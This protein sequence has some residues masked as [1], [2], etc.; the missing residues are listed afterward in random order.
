V[1]E[2]DIEIAISSSLLSCRNRKRG[3]LGGFA[4][5]AAIASSEGA[6]TVFIEG[7]RKMAERV[8]FFSMSA[9][10]A[11]AEAFARRASR[12]FCAWVEEG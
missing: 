4:I 8:G 3:I 6:K 2:A 5:H 7:S 10:K 9:A 1:S 11:D 12:S